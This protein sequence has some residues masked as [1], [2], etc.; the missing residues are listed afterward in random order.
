MEMNG[1][2]MRPLGLKADVALD[3]RKEQMLR[4]IEDY[5]LTYLLENLIGR[6]GLSGDDAAEAV[7]ELK[8]YFGIIALQDSPL[9]IPQDSVV[10]EAWH[11]F[12]V[13]TSQYKKFCKE[14][15]G[16]F[17]EHQPRTKQ[18]LVPRSALYNLVN[19]YKK[20]Y[21][22]MGKAWGTLRNDF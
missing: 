10:D 20:Y 4:K 6:I 7:F 16:E 19:C 11:E 2:T 22:K 8:R 9:G 15:F 14:V 3:E 5:D 18:F 1:I 12:I 13:F 17:I 21:G